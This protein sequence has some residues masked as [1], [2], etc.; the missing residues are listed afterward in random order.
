[1]GGH[2]IRNAHRFPA[3]EFYPR[4]RRILDQ[5]AGALPESRIRPVPFYRTKDSFGDFDVLVES[6]GLGPDWIPMASSAL[7]AGEIVRNGEVASFGAD[8]L[9][10]DL[11]LAP[12][13]QFDFSLNYFSWNDLGNL[14]GRIARKVGFKFG[15]RGLFYVLREGDYH[16]SDVLVTRNFDAALPFLGFDALRYRRGFDTLVDIF[17]F[18][19]DSSYFDPEV[20]PLQHRSHAA[21]VSDRKRKTYWEFLAWIQDH[22]APKKGETADIDFLSL[23]E[24][25]FPRFKRRLQR[26]KRDLEKMR[27]AKRRFNGNKV[28]QWTG[29]D[30]EL[31]G[32]LMRRLTQS[33]G[34][35]EGVT[36]YV[37]SAAESEVRLW[38]SREADHLRGCRILD[39]PVR[40]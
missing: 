20:F 27:A 38:V 7:L 6:D 18:V 10:V 5:L 12:Q 32:E 14:M 35:K 37:L 39:F 26:E 40:S 11:I 13:D 9:Q 8:G 28:R 36:E 19:A 16:V 15:H 4:A 2:A 21:R 3:E 33:K 24:N 17:R 31:L 29:L 25:M 22:Q 1:M 30:G 23:A 34:G